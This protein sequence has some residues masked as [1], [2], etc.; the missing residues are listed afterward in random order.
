MVGLVRLS[1]LLHACVR[2]RDREGMNL[3]SR[4]RDPA[5]RFQTRFLIRKG[6]KMSQS[7]LRKNVSKTLAA[8]ALTGI[9][10]V[11]AGSLPGCQDAGN[12]APDAAGVKHACKGQNAC[13]GQGGCKV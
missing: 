4:M 3:G 13:K 2:R 1:G 6:M 8:A 12:K 7:Q 10:A 11:S 9:L 5:Y